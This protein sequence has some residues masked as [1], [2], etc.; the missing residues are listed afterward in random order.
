MI[1]PSITKSSTLLDKGCRTY[2]R[3]RKLVMLALVLCG[4]THGGTGCT[5]TDNVRT[6]KPSRQPDQI[7]ARRPPVIR[8]PPVLPPQP[9][10]QPLAGRTIIVDPGHGG[11]DPGTLGVGIIEEKTVNLNV[12]A[13]LTRRLQSGGAKVISSRTT[14]VFIPLDDRADLA[15]QSRTDLLVS[16][17]ADACSDPSVTGAT[18]FIARNASTQSIKAAHKISA[19]LQRAGIECRGVRRA[20]FRV[21]VKHSRPSLLIEC[22]FL[23]NPQEARQLSLPPYQARVADAIA[24]GILDHFTQ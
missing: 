11:R 20:G 15:E 2:R 22:G 14:D 16:I 21:L 10:R 8:R 13:R 19:S 12:S 23:T 5:T 3:R 1:N 4:I 9:R 17:H 24:A 6:R 18:I 7:H